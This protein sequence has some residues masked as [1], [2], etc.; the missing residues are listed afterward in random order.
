M[1][2]RPACGPI[3]PTTGVAT[4]STLIGN[5]FGIDVHP[6]LPRVLDA[7]AD[8]LGRA[9][10]AGTQRQRKAVPVDELGQ[11][12]PSGT[13]SM[14]EAILSPSS[15]ATTHPGR[16]SS[17]GPGMPGGTRWHRPNHAR[18]TTSLGWSAPH[19]W[20]WSGRKCA[21]AFDRCRHRGDHRD[22]CGANARSEKPTGRHYPA[23]WC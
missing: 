3:A 16:R 1:A 14:P 21:Q 9:F 11:P 12:P 10:H 23:R 20:C 17:S 22:A 2:T 8:L 7:A 19:R 15:T 13:T 6:R 18:S 4:S 5:H